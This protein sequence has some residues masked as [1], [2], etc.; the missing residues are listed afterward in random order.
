HW[1]YVVLPGDTLKQPFSNGYVRGGAA[2]NVAAYGVVGVEE[3]ERSVSS[4][5]LDHLEGQVNGLTKGGQNNPLG[6]SIRGNTTLLGTGTPLIAVGPFA[7]T[8]NILQ[9]INA[10]DLQS[11]TALKDAAAAGV[12]GAYSGNGVLEYTPKEGDYNKRREINLIVNTTVV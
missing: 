5:V 1:K 2:G 9:D 3:L 6:F 7:Y 8:G 4:N 12:W 10:Y 11:V